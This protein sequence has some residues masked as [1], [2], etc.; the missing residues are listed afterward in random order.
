MVEPGG[1]YHHSNAAHNLLSTIREADPVNKKSGLPY[2]TFI[3]VADYE[4]RPARASGYKDNNKVCHLRARNQ[5]GAV[6]LAGRDTTACTL[7]MQSRPDLVF[8]D[9]RS[10]AENDQSAP[11]IDWSNVETPEWGA[12]PE[13][14]DDDP[15]TFSPKRWYE[16]QP[17]PWTYIPFNGGPHCHVFASDNNSLLPTW[18][19]L[20]HGYS[21]SIAIQKGE[22]D[23]QR[24]EPG[25]C[26]WGDLGIFSAYWRVTW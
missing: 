7:V 20:L 3:T 10:A 9:P 4:H 25:A 18:G 19:T 8:L 24:G 17:K 16:W 15:E 1:V 21:R 5:L 22:A 6:L 12:I 23:V 13:D 14:S 2:N 11:A 26:R